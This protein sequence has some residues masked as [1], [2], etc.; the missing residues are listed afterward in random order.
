MVWHEPDN[1]GDA[2]T[3]YNVQYKETT[4]LTFFGEDKPN[5][6]DTVATEAISHTGTDTTAT[7]TELEADTSYHVRVQAANGEGTGPWS[8]V[9]PDRPTRE[10]NS[11]PVFAS[12][13]DAR[14]VLRTLLPERTSA[15]R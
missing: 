15:P 8:L 11:P 3:E 13:S 12:G 7:I 14:S 5:N 10:N 4:G 1:T 9:G 6:P 2:I